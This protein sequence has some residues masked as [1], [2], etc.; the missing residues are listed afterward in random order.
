MSCTTVFKEYKALLK[1]KY[2]LS[3]NDCNK[4][5]DKCRDFYDEAY[6]ED[7]VSGDTFDDLNEA[8]AKDGNA[9]SI[10]MTEDFLT[11]VKK[12]HLR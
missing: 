10:K 9:N 3:E 1:D 11:L 2:K 6:F 7:D 12:E 4:A 8:L 5:C